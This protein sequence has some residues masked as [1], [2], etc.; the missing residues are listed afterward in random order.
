MKG[1]VPRALLV[2]IDSL[3]A[4][5]HREGDYAVICETA[6]THLP[7]SS[8]VRTAGCRH[9]VRP[10]ED[11]D[12]SGEDLAQRYQALPWNDRSADPS[13]RSPLPATC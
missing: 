5:Y 11:T 8:A 1:S 7:L 2:G 10:N 9:Q 3:E 13:P 4:P 6:G 12:L